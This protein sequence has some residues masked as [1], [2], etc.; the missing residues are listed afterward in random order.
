MTDH[1]RPNWRPNRFAYDLWGC[2]LDFHFPAVKLLDFLG[3]EA[4]LEASDN[5]FALITRRIWRPYKRD[6]IPRRGT[7]GRSGWSA[8]CTNAE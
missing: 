6:E 7:P 2:G 8:S 3:Q 1:S 4:V 5:P